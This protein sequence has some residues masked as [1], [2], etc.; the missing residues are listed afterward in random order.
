MEEASAC[1]S[2][3][4]GAAAGLSVTLISRAE[5]TAT[6][7]VDLASAKPEARTVNV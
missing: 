7:T 5:L 3:F 2:S 4:C 1:T 6:L